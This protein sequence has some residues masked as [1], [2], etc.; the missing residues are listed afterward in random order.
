MPLITCPDCKN[1]ISDS[2]PVCP[3]CGRPK[4]E[5]KPV[6]VET[7]PEV[8]KRSIGALLGIGILFFPILFSW[9]T[10]RKG[11]S[12]TPKLIAFSWLI[13]MTVLTTMPDDDQQY[14]TSVSNSNTKV[15]APFVKTKEPPKPL[16]EEDKT[17]IWNLGQFV[18]DFGKPSGKKFVATNLVGTFS[19]TATQDSALNIRFLISSSNQIDIMLFEYGRNNPVKSYGSGDGYTILVLDQDSQRLK[20]KAMNYS[21]R[22]SL[23][24]SNSKRLNK[25]LMKGG[26]VQFVVREIENPTSEYSFII[27]DA[28][29]YGNAMRKLKEK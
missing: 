7:S 11:Y 16:A 28:G 8:E 23:N 18:D 13:I 20:L 21:D 26:Q 10:L 22:L 2:A 12:S 4:D 15:K 3:K 25:A 24:K 19:N 17:G 27:L 1:E 9:F 5:E 14:D 29:Y 6:T